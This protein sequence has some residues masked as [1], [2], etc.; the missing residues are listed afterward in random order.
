MSNLGIGGFVTLTCVR[1]SDEFLYVLL[2]ERPPSVLADAIN[3]F[4]TP[5]VSSGWMR[6]QKF[7]WLFGEGILGGPPPQE[8]HR[9]TKFLQ[10][11]KMVV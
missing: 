8:S 10:P 7:P 4:F 11:K 1:S 2:H 3:G 9:E 5:N 6:V